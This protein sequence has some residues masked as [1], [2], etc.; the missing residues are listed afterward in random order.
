MRRE[1]LAAA[2]LAGFL[3]GHARAQ[4]LTAIETDWNATF[5]ALKTADAVAAN[6]AF[7]RFNLALRS[8]SATNQIDWRTEYL[9][10]SLDCQFADTRNLGAQVLND[11]L[12]NNRALNEQGNAELSR[13]LKACQ[14]P[15]QS[16]AAAPPIPANLL[17]ASA[18]FT[19]PG[20]SGA[21]KSGDSYTP[22]REF[23]SILAK[24]SSVELE[25]RRVPV[26]N[27]Q[28][29]L[30]HALTSI[31]QPSEGT[32]KG[33]FAVAELHGT[34]S[35][36][37]GV[38]DCLARYASPM[39]IEFQIE[40]SRFMLTVY[41]VPERVDVY[42]MARRLHGLVLPPGVIAYSVPEDMSL[43]SQGGLFDCGSM[44]HEMVH[45][46]IKDKFPGAPAWLEE[47]LASEVAV[48]NPTPSKFVFGWS[49][50]DKVLYPETE[51]RPTI[52]ELLDMSWAD[53]SEDPDYST[54]YIQATAAVFVRYLDQRG[55]LQPVYFAVR[56][57]H[58]AADL[59][60][61]RSYREILEDVF[62]E[63]L[64]TIQ[65]DFNT[66]FAQQYRVNSPASES[67]SDPVSSAPSQ[68]VCKTPED[69]ADLQYHEAHP[70]VQ[71]KARC[72]RPLPP[73]PAANQSERLTKPTS[74]DH[75]P[76]PPQL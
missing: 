10:G 54:S 5:A 31:G 8:Y 53:F 75:H 44:A 70:E 48:A 23:H 3:A 67:Y 56:D 15:V 69:F 46:L 49:W 32:T 12:Q 61:Y 17:D 60:T 30:D 22:P 4:T 25:A 28:A 39:K 65:A 50:R 62:H 59:S 13:V 34:R 19:Q 9:A 2:V 33:G 41:V 55:K 76:N 29:A 66:W 47:G 45:L 63:P 20:V 14:A 43:T 68:P 35:D 72:M 64:N 57:H 51:G 7:E 52:N 6:A 11:I 37:A 1:M 24:V 73:F 26:S 42:E 21:T 18:H 40:P 16:S 71:S 27:P 36:A 58:L 74:D 38:A